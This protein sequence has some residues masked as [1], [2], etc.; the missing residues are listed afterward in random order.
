[1]LRLR[2]GFVDGCTGRRLLLWEGPDGGATITIADSLE[3]YQNA[4]LDLYSVEL[5]AQ[6][7]SLIASRGRRAL[8]TW[9][10]GT[11]LIDGDDGPEVCEHPDA[12]DT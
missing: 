10:D 5:L 6:M 3:D 7:L 9:C 8:C 2:P 11:G 1:M 4:V 12:I